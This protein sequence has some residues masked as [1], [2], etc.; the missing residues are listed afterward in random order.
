LRELLLA[1]TL[2]GIVPAIASTTLLPINWFGDPLAISISELFL[3]Y[4]FKWVYWACL[5][6]ALLLA[7]VARR[8]VA[9]IMLAP[10]TLLALLPN[11]RIELRSDLLWSPDALM[12]EV[13]NYLD[14][15]FYQPIP[16]TSVSTDDLLAR[17]DAANAANAA[18]RL[19]LLGDAARVFIAQYGP[20]ERQQFRELALT[21]PAAP[22]ASG[23]TA[24]GILEAGYCG[25]NTVTR[26]AVEAALAAAAGAPNRVLVEMTAYQKANDQLCTIWITGPSNAASKTRSMAIS[27]TPVSCLASGA[28]RRSLLRTTRTRIRQ[29]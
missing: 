24:Y 28:G 14:G 15:A 2:V 3:S 11:T 5:A 18:A 13:T 22:A 10:L 7:L 25:E 9:V 23:L 12:A 21:L 8:V 19:P 6:L 27:S 17:L 1:V 16:A 20:T 4:P 29:S 26:A